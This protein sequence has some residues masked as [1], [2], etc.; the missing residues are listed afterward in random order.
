METRINSI[1]RADVPTCS[2]WAIGYSHC[3]NGSRTPFLPGLFGRE[4]DSLLNALAATIHT[5]GDKSTE[6]TSK[7]GHTLTG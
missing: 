7:G 2:A 1:P 3:E 6:P 5:R 4:A